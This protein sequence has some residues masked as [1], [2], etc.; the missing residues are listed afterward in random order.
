MQIQSAEISLQVLVG[1]H[2]IRSPGNRAT[3]FEK[4]EDFDQFATQPRHIVP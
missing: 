1:A 4:C 2:C 3:D